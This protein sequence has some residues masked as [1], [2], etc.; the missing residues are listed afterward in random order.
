M[1]LKPLG[2]SVRHVRIASW[3]TSIAAILALSSCSTNPRLM[4]DRNSSSQMLTVRGSLVYRERIAL[5]ADSV[6]HISVQDVSIADRPAD[7]IASANIELEGQ[8]VPFEFE[9]PVDR[10]KLQSNHRYALRATIE[11]NSGALLWTTTEAHLVEPG[12]SPVTDLG[13]VIL[14]RVTG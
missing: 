5:P 6:A 3:L 13:A 8:Q 11:V 2:R 14:T 1:P 7:V 12:M 10:M 4:A 9:I